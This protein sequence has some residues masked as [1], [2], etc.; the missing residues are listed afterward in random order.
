M[1]GIRSKLALG[2]GVA[3]ALAALFPAVALAPSDLSLTK[4]DSP[5]PVTEGGQLTYTIEVRN[6]GPDPATNVV[7]SDDLVPGDVDL[8]STTPSQGNCSVQGGKKI[9]CE[10]GTLA[11]GA[12]ASVVI[13]VTAKKPGTIS[14]TASVTSD[15]ADPQPA[16][17]SATATTTVLDAGPKPGGPTCKGKAA[18]IVGTEGDD[19]ITGTEKNDVIVAL[20]GNDTVNGLGG[21]DRI[22][23]GAGN[24][25]VKGKS[26]GDVV[27]GGGGND[28][29]RGGGDNDNLGGGGGKDRLGGGRGAD[30][31]NGGRGN[32]HCNGGPGKDTKR[33]C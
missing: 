19:T 30:F 15:V 4:S 27:R 20:G 12:N 17:N 22:C 18:T 7:V 2:S 13:L 1:A 31:L 29:V 24:D 14:N 11:S 6:D 32:D 25:T 28:K 3:L 26:G 5:D 23:G 10:L 16:N 9:T 33:S 8:I 21:K